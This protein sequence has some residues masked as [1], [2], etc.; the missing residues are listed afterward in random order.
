[1]AVDVRQR[2]EAVELYLVQEVGVIEGFGNAQQAHR[3][4]REGISEAHTLRIAYAS[5]GSEA[6]AGNDRKGLQRTG[7]TA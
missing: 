2:T 1:M 5:V 3:A 6:H 4:Q 7:A